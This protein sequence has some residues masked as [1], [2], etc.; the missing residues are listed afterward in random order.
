MFRAVDDHRSRLIVQF[1]MKQA[2]VTSITGAFRLTVDTFPPS[3]TGGK[4]VSQ[5][6]T[7]D[8]AATLR[9][10]DVG[11]ILTAG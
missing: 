10:V 3:S 4:A 11:L 9:A 7:I 1:E 5:I 8:E 6:Q 2:L